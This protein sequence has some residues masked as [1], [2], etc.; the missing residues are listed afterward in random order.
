MV[1]AESRL[2]LV[3]VLLKSDDTTESAQRALGWLNTH[4][5]VERAL[6]AAGARDADHL[7]GVASVGL[8]TSRTGEFVVDLG[9]REHPLTAV[10]DENRPV[11]FSGGA[12][13]PATPFG[14][15]PFLALPLRAG[16]RRPAVGLLLV[17]TVQPRPDR[18]VRWL[19][20]VLADKLQRLQ[21]RNVPS[22]RGLDR[23]RQLLYSVVNAVTDPILLTDSRGKL[24]MGN[25]RAEQLLAFDD[26]HSEG[27]RHAV[28]LNNLFFSAAL[29]SAAVGRSGTAARELVLVDPED[30]SE[31]LFELLTSAV[32]VGSADSAFVSIL[33]NVTD[34]RRA[35]EEMED[36]YRRL[37]AAEAQVRA[38]RNRLELIVN[39]VAHP[40][41]VN[42]PTGEILMTNAPA[43]GLFTAAG[44]DA[45][46]QRCVQSNVAQFSSFMSRLF[47]GGAGDQL[48]G[49]L[50]LTHPV[51]SRQMP[52]EAFAATV[53]APDTEMVAIVTVLHDLT[54]TIERERLYAE[55]K[56]VSS[57]LEARVR[58]ATAELAEQNEVL[59]RQ[60]VALEQASA[61]K[62]QFLA[63]I[64]HE[65]RTP[66]NAIL[67]YTWMLLQDSGG[68]LPADYR[69][70]LLKVDANSRHLAALINDVLD[71]SQIEA[72]QMPVQISAF[73]VDALLRE[74]LEELEAMIASSPVP[75]LL[76]LP[77]PLPPLESDRQKVKQ[78]L[79]NLITNAKKFTQEGQVTVSAHFDQTNGAMHLAV[80]DTGVGIPSSDLER[81]FDAFQQASGGAATKSP[82]SGLGL[83]I[84]RRLAR[85]LGGEITVQSAVGSGSTFTLVLPL[86]PPGVRRAAVAGQLV[87]VAPR[88][89]REVPL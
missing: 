83:T 22:D 33:R 16:R 41:I 21:L 7:W 61:A 32:D 86:E 71:I 20:R 24:L 65:F 85:V 13:Q 30:G 11:H 2:A 74:V 59:K 79:V 23:E 51:T 9:D 62:S 68:S 28:G 88:A 44:A 58:A 72:G 18:D 54:E 6:C 29:A 81:I 38:E 3:E 39:A 36:N 55:L 1:P 53:F 26:H 46:V 42:T 4:V 15:M 25:T 80:L 73:A 87:H 52:V 37:R 84:S 76:D 27:W 8:S 56:V 78:V 67:G 89:A 34:L 66:L 49:R 75:V 69:R 31:L 40:I 48:R 43:E 47:L 60:A 12:R 70:W 19:S 45:E 63:N 82:G 57:Q 10:L 5:G 77:G 14:R 50:A 64:S 17:E 35:R